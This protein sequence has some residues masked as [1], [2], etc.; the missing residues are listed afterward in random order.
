MTCS[1]CLSV[2]KPSRFKI[3]RV[4]KVWVNNS[5]LTIHGLAASEADG[6][7]L[8]Y[9]NLVINYFF[10]SKAMWELVN[11]HYNTSWTSN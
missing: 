4:P 10:Q 2:S 9:K 6:K 1:F 5:V 8:K 3:E 11:A 7:I